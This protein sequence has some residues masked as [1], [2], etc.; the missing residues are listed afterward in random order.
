V[1]GDWIVTLTGAAASAGAAR[2]ARA[3]RATRGAQIQRGLRSMAN[4]L[5]GYLRPR[6]HSCLRLA[7]VPTNRPKMANLYVWLK[8][9]HVL[10]VVT[11]LLTHGITAGTALSLRGTVSQASRGL[12]KLSQA[13]SAASYPSLLLVVVTGVWM[14][15]AA[16]WW[17]QA[18]PWVAI[19]VLVAVLGAMFWIARPYY[20]ARDAVAQRDEVIADRLSK[21]R[22]IAAFWIGGV[23]LLV[24]VFLMVVK[25]S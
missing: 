13:S 8:F 16:H 9:F 2:T 12:L 24:L 4:L 11:F 20:Q 1:V 25:P 14:T 21:T 19:V 10:G 23:G 22:P 15:F 18:W 17:G 5:S 6:Q 7:I 3:N